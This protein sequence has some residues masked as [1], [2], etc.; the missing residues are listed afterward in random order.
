MSDSFTAKTA[1]S[2]SESAPFKFASTSVPSNGGS[3]LFNFFYGNGQNQNQTS[4][5]ESEA[6]G[7]GVIIG[8]TEDELLMVTNNHVAVY[9][10]TGNTMYNSYTA[11]TKERK[12]TFVD[13]LV[14][15]ITFVTE[16]TCGRHCA[17]RSE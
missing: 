6:Y 4:T 8:K 2:A 15:S 3:D 12:V 7:S 1:I 5:Q 10:K 11:S 9:D 17:A 13:V 16:T 14:T